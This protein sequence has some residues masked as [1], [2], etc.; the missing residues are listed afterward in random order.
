MR[1]DS[2]GYSFAPLALGHR[3]VGQTIDGCNQRTNSIAAS[4]GGGLGRPAGAGQRRSSGQVRREG[5]M[6][7]RSWQTAVGTAL[8]LLEEP[9][10]R[11]KGLPN[12]DTRQAIDHKGG[13][14]QGPRSEPVQQFL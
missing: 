1:E 4:V 8:P 2:W 3:L 12:R 6:A 13:K 7:A 10:S 5:T 9:L 14:S 11:R